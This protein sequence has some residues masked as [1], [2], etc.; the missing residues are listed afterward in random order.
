MP[1]KKSR[2]SRKSNSGTSARGKLAA[3]E[4]NCMKCKVARKVQNPHVVTLKNGRKMLK[5]VCGVC[6]TRVNKFVSS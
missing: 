3:D 2:A 5:G 6:G 1:A 4:A